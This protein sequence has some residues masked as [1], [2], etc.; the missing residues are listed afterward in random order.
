MAD[1][2]QLPE[3]SE[4]SKKQARRHIPPITALAC[5]ACAIIF[6]IL[7]LGGTNDF[8]ALLQR[9][10]YVGPDAVWDGAWWG[11]LTSPFVHV[12]VW[13]VGFNVYWLWTMGGAFERRF[14]SLRLAAFILL[15]SWI[16]SAV[17]LF[18]GTTGIGISGVVYALFGFLWV[19]R[20]RIDEF[21]AVMPDKTA[22]W[23]LTW[24]VLC[25]WLD[26]VGAVR[27]ANA[28]HA[29]GLAFGALA[30][31]WIARPRLRILAGI[32]MGAL[33]ILSFVPLRGTPWTASWTGYRATKAMEK[34]DY[35]AAIVWLR[36]SL[37][38]GQEPSWTWFMLAQNYGYLFRATEQEGSPRHREEY[39]EALK[40]LRSVNPKSADQVEGMYGKPGP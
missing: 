18:T 24:F 31:L 26:R 22:L 9:V 15:S 35:E 33:V 17:E 3:T 1:V 27:I 11:L 37:A 14:S 28:A 16:S 2:Q 25:F 21:R 32:G 12:E 8:D 29:G 20:V 39:V 6:L 30:G 34:H 4:A 7:N 36:K 19:A 40:Q 13:H 5:L 10:G 38:Q 23:F